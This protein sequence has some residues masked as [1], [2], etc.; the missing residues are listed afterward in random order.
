MKNIIFN[1]IYF[2][3]YFRNKH[4]FIGGNNRLHN[5]IFKGNNRI[6]KNTF[7]T[8]GF[9]NYGSYV[10]TDCFFCYTK[11]G[12]YC[13]IGNNVNI[14]RS[15]HPSSIFV[16]THPAFFSIVK[17][18]GF[19]YVQQQKFNEFL[20]LDKNPNISVIIGNDVWI[21][22][23]VT[24]MG[25]VKIGDG[26]IVGTKALITKDVEPYSIV[27]GVPAK[28]IKNRFDEEEVNILL[29]IKWWDKDEKWILE[30]IDLF[31]NI[32]EFVKKWNY[33]FNNKTFKP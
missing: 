30:N 23:D 1:I 25:G 18:A 17:Q 12:K 20:M 26:A 10:G 6:G 22:N 21:G 15:T 3:K 16:S 5:S 28:F 8:N 19:T 29:N 13:S 27:G 2:F 32:D 9:L 14:V 4:I 24:I 7:F 31:S 11:I 33:E